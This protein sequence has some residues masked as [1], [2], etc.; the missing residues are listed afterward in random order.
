M[1]YYKFVVSWIPDIFLFN[2]GEHF[3]DKWEKLAFMSVEGWKNWPE[4]Q[5]ATVVVMF[6][7]IVSNLLNLPQVDNS[8]GQESTRDDR[9]N[10]KDLT[11]KKFWRP[12]K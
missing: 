7:Q 6:Y 5:A 8:P 12:E 11:A 1:N 10:F 4:V 3:Q 2:L 9:D